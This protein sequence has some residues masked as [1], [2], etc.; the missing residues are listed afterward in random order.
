MP[1]TQKQI[2]NLYTLL[3]DYAWNNAVGKAEMMALLADMKTYCLDGKWDAYDANYKAV[4]QGEIVRRIENAV[5]TA[6]TVLGTVEG[7]DKKTR[8]VTQAQ[9]VG[10]FSADAMSILGLRFSQFTINRHFQGH[11]D[12]QPA[13]LADKEILEVAK[14]LNQTPA[15]SID[16]RIRAYFHGGQWIALNN[17]GFA[18]HSLANV[19]P[20]RIVFDTQLS[21]DE[22]ERLGR[23][24]DAMDL[25]LGDSIPA[26]R[27]RKQDWDAVIPSMFTGVP[28]TRN[29][30]RI[31]YSIKAIKMSGGAADVGN[32]AVM[33]SGL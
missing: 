1:A 26:S 18:L 6:G 2:T 27:R 23:R 31:I 28:E 20:R 5:P 29:S 22:Q 15:L 16:M 30:T 32:A 33:N 21:S 9:A 19:V 14:T 17:R 4:W 3:T 10:A 24:F 7:P 12:G 8:S 13:W 25:N 11:Y